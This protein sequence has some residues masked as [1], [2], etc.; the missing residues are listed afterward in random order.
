MNRYRRFSMLWIIGLVPI[1]LIV[2]NWTVLLVGTTLEIGPDTTFVTEPLTADGRIDYPAAIHQRYSKGVT[3]ENNAAVLIDQAFGVSTI[4]PE[5]RDQY[6]QWLGIDP[7]PEQGDYVVT[8]VKFVHQACR[9][10][11]RHHQPVRQRH[12]CP[13]AD[14]HVF[15]GR[16][17][18]EPGS[19]PPRPRANWICAGGLSR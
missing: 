5:L 14:A 6:F 13:V 11:A 2:W 12:T 3:P 9:R 1:C 17:G 18:P 8:Q 15:A 16:C 7:L 10:L 19:S 4:A